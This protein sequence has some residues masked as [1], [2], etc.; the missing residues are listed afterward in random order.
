MKTNAA[1]LALLPLVG[2]SLDSLAD[3]FTATVQFETIAPVQIYENQVVD[4]GR[5][6]MKRRGDCEMAIS[7]T[8]I[9][10]AAL[11]NATATPG[12]KNTICPTSTDLTPGQYELSGAN[13][14]VVTVSLIGVNDRLNSPWG[15]EPSGI[16]YPLGVTEASSGITNSSAISNGGVGTQVNLSAGC[17]V[18]IYVGG[19]LSINDIDTLNT[20]APL[21]STF[22]IDVVY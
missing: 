7:P 11:A 8:T 13:S 17:Q 12:A 18:I 21:S 6:I 22:T 2:F 5:M 19:I 16:Y 9:A 10:D 20:T 1:F 3:P 14:A 4:F 15:Y